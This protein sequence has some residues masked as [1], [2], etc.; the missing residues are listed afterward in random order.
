MGRRWI[1]TALGKD[2]PGIVA[3]VTKILYALGCNLEDSAM[4]RL[5]DEFAVMLI[6]SGPARVTEAVL[7]KAYA[8]LE[9]RLGLVVH[10]KALTGPEASAPK[11]RRSR[12]LLS[13]YG[14]DRPGIVYRV[15]Q[16]LA[17]RSV[18]IIDVHT[19]YSGAGKR[20]RDPSLYS[21]LLEI[22]LPSG[23]SA[24]WLQRE[25]KR[26]TRALGVEASLR[27]SEADVL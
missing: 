26:A 16:M 20:R 9:R 25:L 19:H 5:E 11:A 4:K 10:L 18:N 7:R 8:P 1:L 6:F 22:E 12:C 2:R 17:G 15:S 24:A 3:R 23:T 27:P 14:A 21:L 13:V